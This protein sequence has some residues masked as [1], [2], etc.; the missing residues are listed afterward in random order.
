MADR[1][2][3][4]DRVKANRAKFLEVL[5]G[6]CNV[7]EA[8]RVIGVS[9]R[10]VYD[11]REACSVFREAWDDAEQEA[12]DKLE[13]VA[14]RRGVEGVEGQHQRQAS[15]TSGHRMIAPVQAR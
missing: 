13:R 5:R 1:T 15:A 12:A 3:R 4:T 8:A 9:R 6:T 7:S 2:I 10:T 14:W 11:W